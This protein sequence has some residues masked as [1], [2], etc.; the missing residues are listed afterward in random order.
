MKR[1]EPPTRRAALGLTAVAMT[2]ITLGALV[3]LPA[4][5]ELVGANLY[6]VSAEAAPIAPIDIA[7]HPTRIEVPEAVA[8]EENL[9]L[10]PQ[11]LRGKHHK[12]GSRGPA[13]T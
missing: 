5:F 11:A 1:Y 10:G 8:P 2:A 9:Q 7:A 4:K 6:S 3:V 13:S 12:L